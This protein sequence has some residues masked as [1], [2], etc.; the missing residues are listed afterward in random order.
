MF[1]IVNFE[2]FEFIFFNKDKSIV[3]I[4]FVNSRSF[5][6]HVMAKMMLYEEI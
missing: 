2:A 4:Q 5:A 3:S 6:I 1:K